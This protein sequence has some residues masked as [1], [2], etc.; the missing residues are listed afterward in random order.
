MRDFHQQANLPWLVAGDFSEI[1]YSHEKE[2]GN[3]RPI[4]MM[5]DFQN[6]LADCGLEDLGYAG[7]IFTWRRG[8]NKG[9]A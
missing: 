1:L 3:L 9:A 6:V 8:R 4:K 7:D 2:G 5:E